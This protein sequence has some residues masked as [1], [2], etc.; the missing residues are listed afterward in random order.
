[1]ATKFLGNYKADNYRELVENQL[2]AYKNL[3]YNTMHLL[4]SHLDFFPQNCGA[5]SDEQGERF[6]KDIA[7]MV[8]EEVEPIYAIAGL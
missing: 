7:T 6:H 2:K 3:A 5:V 1:M 4:H 8:S